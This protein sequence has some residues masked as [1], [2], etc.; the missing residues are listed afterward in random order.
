MTFTQ[1]TG[2]NPPNNETVFKTMLGYMDLSD[3]FYNDVLVPLRYKSFRKALS[4]DEEQK[5]AILERA[6]NND[7]EEMKVDALEF[8]KLIMATRYLLET[9]NSAVVDW[10]SMDADDI[11]NMMSTHQ[12]ALRDGEA[13]KQVSPDKE[14]ETGSVVSEATSNTNL[15]TSNNGFAKRSLSAFK[16]C[17][18]PAQPITAK[19]MKSFK[20]KI[21]NALRSMDMDQMIDPDYEPPEEGDPSYAQYVARNKFL[22]SVWIDITSNPDHEARLWLL[23]KAMKNDGRATWF[24]ILEHDNSETI[25]ASLIPT[26]MARWVN[27]KLDKIH[28]GATQSFIAMNASCLSTLR[29]ENS[30]MPDL[31]ALAIFL[32]NVTH[33]KS[34]GLCHGS[35]N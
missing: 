29:E 11:Y 1:P 12:K 7:D 27:T 13:A 34:P 23:E 5:Q 28:I 25:E 18:L 15:G 30:P 21:E 3:E 9:T 35:E 32:A 8:C 14:V 24:K 20:I 4:I 17:K 22:Y 26:T 10:T 2:A 33:E 31:C 16:E 6:M 19:A